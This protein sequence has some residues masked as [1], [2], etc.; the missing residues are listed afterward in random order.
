MPISEDGNGRGQYGNVRHNA[1]ELRRNRDVR[2]LDDGSIESIDGT[3]FV[4]GLPV[5]VRRQPVVMG[6]FSNASGTYLLRPIDSLGCFIASLRYPS[7]PPISR[8]I[9]CT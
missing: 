8:R 6:N 1:A 3:D 9:F 5:S 2:Y 4:I 7:T